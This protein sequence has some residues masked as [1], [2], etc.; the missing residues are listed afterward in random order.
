M[1]KADASGAAYAVIVGADELAA[2]GATVKALRAVDAT[3]AFAAQRIVP[4]DDLAEA[5]VNAL[6]DHEQE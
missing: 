1:K 2:A 4:V 3:A 6:S 5:L